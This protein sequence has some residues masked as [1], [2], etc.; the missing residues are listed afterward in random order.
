VLEHVE[1]CPQLWQV[2]E[3]FARED[4][5]AAELGK[6]GAPTTGARPRDVTV[7]LTSGEFGNEHFHYGSLSEGVDA[8]QRL[9][10]AAEQGADGIGRLIGIVVNPG[11][12]YGDPQ[13]VAEDEVE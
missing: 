4:A 1:R 5:L 9:V 7:V 11:P 3:E 12:L 8:I 10:L 6:S 13:C 2:L